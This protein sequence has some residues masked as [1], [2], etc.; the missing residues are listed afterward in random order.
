L[1]HE[2]V[3]LDLIANGHPNLP[4]YRGKCLSSLTS[5]KGIVFEIDAFDT[6]ELALL[7]FVQTHNS[8][9]VGV[10]VAIQLAYLLH[11]LNVRDRCSGFVLVSLWLCRF[12][13]YVT[14]F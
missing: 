14:V 7:Q 10:N 8:W 4:H 12:S 1:T 3:I 9:C 13:N 5:V 2:A 11:Y 6:A